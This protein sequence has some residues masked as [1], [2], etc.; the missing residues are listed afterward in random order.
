[1]TV[2]IISEP[3][4]EV[5]LSDIE[6]GTWEDAIS[7]ADPPGVNPPVFW[8][9]HL[10]SVRLST[11]GRISASAG[12]PSPESAKQALIATLSEQGIGVRP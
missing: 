5:S 8:E 4:P 9:A 7:F 6:Y 12:G 1:M 2:S 11:G 10:T 3:R